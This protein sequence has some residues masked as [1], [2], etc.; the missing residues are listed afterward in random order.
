[1][2]EELLDEVPVPASATVVE[3]GAGTGKLTRLLAPRFARVVAVEPDA[4]MRAGTL[5]LLWEPVRRGGPPPARGGHAALVVA[6]AR[7]VHVR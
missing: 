6:Q 4:E 2:P 7:D 1:V 3:L 5:A